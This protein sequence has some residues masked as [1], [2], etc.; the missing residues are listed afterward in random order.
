MKTL[1]CTIAVLGLFAMPLLAAENVKLDL[2]GRLAAGY[3]DQGQ[4]GNSTPGSFVVP[5]AKIQANAKLAEDITGVI[6]L[7]FDGGTANGA[8]YMY[9]KLDNVIN[10]IANTKSLVNPVITVGAFK[11]DFGEETWSNNVVENAL[12]NNSVTDPS[13]NGVGIQFKQND[14]IPSL[15]L[16]LILGV[17]LAFFNGN[18]NAATDNNNAKAYALKVSGTLKSTPLYFSISDYG[19]GTLPCVANSSSLVVGD[20]AVN[21]PI[22]GLRTKN[23]TRKVYE[24]DVRYDMLEGAAKFEPTK[25]PLWSDSKGVFRLAYGNA[26]DS[27]DAASSRV[28]QAYI[29]LDAIY[30]VD[31]KWYVAFRYSYDDFGVKGATG[32]PLGKYTSISF[33]GGHRITDS[34]IL[35]LDYTTNTEPTA[36]KV[37]DNSINLILSTKW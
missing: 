20:P 22:A 37:D 28:T 23:W 18:G 14:L 17:S 13:G 6:R 34:T 31:K 1:L 5:D 15:R 10:K 32:G 16:P 26:T 4:T 12:V 24:L 2:N 30:N 19:S 21:G 25:A 8:D 36:V 11:I 29:M 3:I 35:K 33:G 27:V 9:I 7:N